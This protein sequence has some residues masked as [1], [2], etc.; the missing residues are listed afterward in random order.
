MNILSVRVLGYL[1]EKDRM[2]F[3]LVE[4]LKDQ[5]HNDSNVRDTLKRLTAKGLTQ[6]VGQH[7]EGSE[8][9]RPQNIYG[10]TDKGIDT[11]NQEISWLNS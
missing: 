11:Y 2:T 3:E 8:P 9:G 10:I 4:L 7:K 6:V 5:N 1:A